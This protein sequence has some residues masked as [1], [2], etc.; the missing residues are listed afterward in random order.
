[1]RPEDEADAVAL[2]TTLDGGGAVTA[3]ALVRAETG[4]DLLLSPASLKA[5]TL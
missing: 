3:A 1:M 2:A 4:E 5:D